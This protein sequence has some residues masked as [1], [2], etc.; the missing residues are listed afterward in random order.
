MLKRFY[1]AVGVLIS[2]EE[3]GHEPAPSRERGPS[4]ISWLLQPEE[5]PAPAVS[6]PPRRTPLWRWLLMP[7]ELPPAGEGGKESTGKPLLTALLAR[8][9]LPRDPVPEQRS[10]PRPWRRPWEKRGKNR[11]TYDRGK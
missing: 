9:T 1:R 7:E 11:S 10:R 4:F 8:E 2:R 5:L 6:V 3:L